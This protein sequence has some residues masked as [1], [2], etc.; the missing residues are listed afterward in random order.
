MFSAAL[1]VHNLPLLPPRGTTCIPPVGSSTVLGAGRHN[2]L[3]SVRSPASFQL[4]RQRELDGCRNDAIK[5]NGNPHNNQP[6]RYSPT[7]RDLAS[8]GV[9][10]PVNHWMLLAE[11]EDHWETSVALQPFYLHKLFTNDI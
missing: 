7:W 11:P 1:G 2:E 6:T 3:Y 9:V 8:L 5:L 4:S 10:V